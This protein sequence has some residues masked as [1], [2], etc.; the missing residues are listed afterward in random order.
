MKYLIV[1]ADDFGLSTGVNEGIIEAF[2]HGIVTSSSL[3]VRQAA[4]PKPPSTAEIIPFLV[5]VCMS[6][7]ENGFIAMGTGSQAMR[8]SH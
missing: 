5:S 6:I 8:S 7:S 1:N 4:A 3:M 2:E